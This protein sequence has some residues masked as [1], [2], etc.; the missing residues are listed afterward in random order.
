VP[1]MSWPKQTVAIRGQKVRISPNS[2]EAEA[3]RTVRT[4]IFFGVPKDEAK[5]ILVTSPAP[6]EGKSTTASNL[7]LAMAQA[8]QKVLIVDADFRRP[9]QHNIFKADGKDGKA[10]GFASLL[11]GQADLQ[12][13]AMPTGT[14]NLDIMPCGPKISNPAEM[15]N[16]DRC[17]AVIRELAAHYD[18]VIIDSPP[19][20]AVTDSQILAVL[21][22][23]VVL[24]V[25]AEVS[26]RRVSMQACENLASVDARPLGV[27]VNDVPRKGGRY[28]YYGGYGYHSSGNR[29]GG[30]G[31]AKKQIKQETRKLIATRDATTHLNRRQRKQADQ[32]RAGLLPEARP[33]RD[34][35]A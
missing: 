10:K 21:C 8:G 26:T 13:A 2:A 29:N 16:S 19:V 34:D 1:S 11:A 12:E 9:M 32:L 15:L 30:N 3:F 4:G 33:D 24:V 18:R 23:V 17:A 28:G 5:T 27:I 7:A 14:E 25:R 31:R 20:V 35:P 6:G 22:D